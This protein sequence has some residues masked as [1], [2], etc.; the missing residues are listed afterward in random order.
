MF[1]LNLK[2]LMYQKSQNYQMFLY[3]PNYPMI[4]LSLMFPTNQMFRLTR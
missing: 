3:F 4:L 1:L 2:S